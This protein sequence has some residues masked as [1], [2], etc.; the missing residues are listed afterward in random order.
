MNLFFAIILMIFVGNI[1]TFS[2]KDY[3][4]SSVE[5]VYSRTINRGYNAMRSIGKIRRSLNLPKSTP[6]KKVLQYYNAYRNI[7]RP[8]R[9]GLFPTDAGLS[10]FRKR[11]S[12]NEYALDKAYPI[13]TMNSDEHIRR[14]FNFLKLPQIQNVPQYPMNYHGIISIPYDNDSFAKGSNLKATPWKFL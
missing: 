7:V 4:M 1:A 9:Y 14:Q 2:Q 6:T 3:G 11:S 12:I 13:Q 10:Y 5:K 8:R